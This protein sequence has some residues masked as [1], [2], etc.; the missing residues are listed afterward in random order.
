[1]RSLA[2]GSGDGVVTLWDVASHE[3]L[4]DLE[5]QHD[6]VI[7]VAFSPD[8]SRLAAGSWDGTVVLYDTD[9]RSWA[10]RA[11]DIA[12]RNLTRSEWRQYFGT[13]S[14]RRTCGQWP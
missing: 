5:T 12:G 6:L 1:V 10:N 14:Y 2:A 11:C 13:R 7:G 4:G 9:P 3:R 8:G